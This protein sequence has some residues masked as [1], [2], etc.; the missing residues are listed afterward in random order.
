MSRNVFSINAAGLSVIKLT[1][2]KTK[3]FRQLVG[4][5]SA[6]ALCVCMCASASAQSQTNRLRVGV[7]DSRA[8]AIAYGNSAEFQES[9]KT[10]RAEYDKAKADKNDK[11]VKEIDAQMKLGQRR[12]H[13]QGFST[14]SV[15]GIMA[16]IKDSLP[17]V[18]RKAGVQVIVSKW[19]L[20]YQ[21][22][23]VEVVDVTDELVA[24]FHPSEKVMGWLKDMKN[25]PP[26]PIEKI[27]D[28]MN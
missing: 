22:P 21:S 5:V 16:K 11:R 7:Y 23:D 13:E 18:A 8:I 27:T 28:D 24:L 6:A 20:N 25:R 2:M 10:V 4:C 9:I 19:E 12:L 1:L 15:A 3:T 17:E 26:I 14:G